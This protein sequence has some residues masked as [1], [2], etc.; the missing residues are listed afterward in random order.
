MRI[1]LFPDGWGNSAK[2]SALTLFNQKE[3]NRKKCTQRNNKAGMLN[4]SYDSKGS[5]GEVRGLRAP[6]IYVTEFS[7]IFQGTGFAT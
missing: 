6:Q 1:E 7:E 3:S 2:N 5:F 4:C